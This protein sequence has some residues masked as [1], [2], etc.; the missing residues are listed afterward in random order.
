MPCQVVYYNNSKIP[1]G[2]VCAASKTGYIAVTVTHE[3]GQSSFPFAVYLD[4]W[5]TGSG[6]QGWSEIG[7]R[8][9]SSS[10]SGT[11]VTFTPTYGATKTYRIRCT[12]YPDMSDKFTFTTDSFSHNG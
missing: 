5:Y 11:N 10:A 6:F 8:T 7:T 3:Q 12:A 4:V 9:G 1:N 2:S